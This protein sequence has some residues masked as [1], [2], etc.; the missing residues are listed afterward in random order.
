M[1]RLLVALLACGLL[2]SMPGCGEPV[3]AARAVTTDEADRL[4]VARFLNYQEGGRAV[5]VA[6]PSSSGQLTITASV[7]FTE[8]V[9]YG[10]LRTKGSKAPGSQGLLQWT[11][12][13]LA[14]R[15]EQ[16]PPAT[17]PAQPPMG[18]WQG[19]RLEA[20]GSSLDTALLLVLNLASDR[21]ENAQLL[22]Q[23]GAR[24]LRTADVDG[25]ECDVFQGPKA[26]G[27]DRA[28]LFYYLDPTGK[29]TKVEATFGTT[30]KPVVVT[31]DQTRYTA[32]KPLKG[33][34]R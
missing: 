23:N 11:P 34:P 4:A 33:M 9:G 6:V 24:W 16:Q 25:L 31:F 7:D 5:E 26:E 21:P 32:V 17:Q 1:R 30:E 13:A 18:G 14:L 8:H 20:K 2:A 12:K 27:A 3:P 29:M 10:V 15:P 22:K 19:R 28:R